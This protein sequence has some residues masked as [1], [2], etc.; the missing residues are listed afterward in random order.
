MVALS[1]CGA[2]LTVCGQTP[3]GRATEALSRL[4]KCRRRWH[5]S[6]VKIKQRFRRAAIAAGDSGGFVTVMSRHAALFY[7]RSD[8]LIVTFDN[9]KSRDLPAPAYPWGYRFVA[10]AGYSHLG[11][12]MVRRNDWFRHAD[13]AAFFSDMRAKGFFDQFRR[14]VFY[15][16]S[17][18]GYAA[19]AYS[20]AAPGCA[21]VAFDPQTSLDPAIVPFETRF[22]R[23]FAR[24]DWTSPSSDAVVSAREAGRIVVFADPFFSIDAAHLRRL[25]GKNL[26]WAKCHWSAHSSARMLH[27]GGILGTVVQQAWDGALTE[28]GFQVE[29]RKLRARQAF[30]RMVLNRA[31]D[32]NHPKLVRDALERLARVKPEW[33]FPQIS[34][35]ASDA[36]KNV[37][38][39]RAIS[40]D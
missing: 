8:T 17:M 10:R 19:L 6:A 40:R 18:G 12:V 3:R 30:A 37:G 25:Q 29:Y 9:M 1:G 36:L 7:R 28:S 2:K 4:A 26:I 35:R 22:R 21:V 34:R 20:D 39:E 33:R 5:F 31:L 16:S 27:M 24:G 13:V 11:I 23:G 14:V 38:E 32:R 15:G